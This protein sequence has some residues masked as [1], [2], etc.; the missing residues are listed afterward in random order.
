MLVPEIALTPTIEAQFRARIGERLAVLHSGLT[1]SERRDE[2]WR[3]QSGEAKAVLGAP[4]AGF[5]PLADLG[6][7]IVD[8]EHDP[9][10]KQAETPS[11]HGRHVAVGWARPAPVTD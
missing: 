3:A 5:A 6:A 11:Y 1:E 9:S 10:F 8:L 4:S 2:W 7:G